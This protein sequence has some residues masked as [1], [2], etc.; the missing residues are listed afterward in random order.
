MEQVEGKE[1][2]KIRVVAMWFLALSIIY[3]IITFWS[4]QT[5]DAALSEDSE[6]ESSGETSEAVLLLNTSI[7]R[8]E[9]AKSLSADIEFRSQ[10]FGEEYW[11]R[12]RYKES[13]TSRVFGSTRR[14]FEKTRFLLDAT[15]TSTSVEDAVQQQGTEENFLTIVCDV[16]AH[17]WW[18]YMSIGGKKSLKRIDFDSLWDKFQQL[19]DKELETLRSRGVPTLNCGLNSLPG[20]GGLA[21]AL[22]RASASFDFEP[23]VEL[24]KERGREFYKITGKARQGV[25]DDAKKTLGVDLLET[26]VLENFPTNV[27]IYFDTKEAFPYR[28]EYYSL[29]GEGKDQKRNNIFRADYTPNSEAVNAEDFNYVQPQSIFESVEGNYIEEIIP[30]VSL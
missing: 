8:L 10:F 15:L 5:V 23:D 7:F 6:L 20:L 22:R 13:S 24:V 3:A 25:Y 30:N 16:A 18:R 28:I 27:A 1:Y 2:L 17:S 19:D 26:Y 21:G 11:G 4:D 9:R 12:G 14:P 29:I